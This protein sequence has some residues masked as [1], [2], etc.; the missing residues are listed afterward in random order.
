MVKCDVQKSK[1]ANILGRRVYIHNGRLFSPFCEI[2]SQVDPFWKDFK[3]WTLS[4]APWIMAPRLHASAPQIMAPRSWAWKQYQFP[5]F[6]ILLWRNLYVFMVKNIHKM[7]IKHHATFG[8]QIFSMYIWK[9][10]R[11]EFQSC[12]PVNDLRVLSTWNFSAHE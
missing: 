12:M 3:K 10:F 11:I 7:F 6:E 4:S 1:G 9:L 2:F 8:I 5:Y